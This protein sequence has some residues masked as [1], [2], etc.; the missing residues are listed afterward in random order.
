MTTT[1]DTSPTETTAANLALA[2]AFAEV[3]GILTNRAELP[4]VVHGAYNF[5]TPDGTPQVSLWFDK[6]DHVDAWADSLGAS[7]ET[8]PSRHH[9]D[10]PFTTREA[11]AIKKHYVHLDLMQMTYLDTDNAAAEPGA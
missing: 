6:P 9:A 8:K 11:K 10:R 4:P 7:A 5:Y 2:E 3:A 1:T